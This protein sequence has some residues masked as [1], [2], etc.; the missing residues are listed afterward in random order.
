MDLVF[1]F[2][3]RMTVLVSGTGAHRRRPDTHCQRPAGAS[4]AVSTWATSAWAGARAM[5]EL[6]RIARR[7]ERRLRQK[8]VVLQS[9]S[10]ALPERRPRWPCWVATAPERDHAHQHT[11]RRHAPRGAR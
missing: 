11:G 4:K 8:R 5:S 6:L 3:S 2:A 9:I 7:P 10:L 1:S